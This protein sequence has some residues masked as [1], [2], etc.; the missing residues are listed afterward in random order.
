MNAT[1]LRGNYCAFSTELIYRQGPWRN[2]EHVE[3]EMLT[4]VDWLNNRRIHE[5]LGYVPPFE[6]EAHYCALS[7]SESLPALEMI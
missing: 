7:E 6:F 5:S 1:T 3:W 4:Y 2:V